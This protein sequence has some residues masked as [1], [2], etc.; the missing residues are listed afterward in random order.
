MDLIDAS[1]EETS[2]S[3]FTKLPFYVPVTAR[4]DGLLEEF[5]RTHQEMAVVV[6]EYGS[7][8]GVLT[9]E[10]VVEEIVG[11]V[12]D[13]FDR[14]GK[15]GFERS[16]DGAFIVDGKYKLDLLEDKLGLRLPRA[17]YETVAGLTSHLFQKVPK[18]GETLEQDGLKITIIDASQ[19]TVR[20]VR[21]EL[22]GQAGTGSKPA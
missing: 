17:G 16:G 9:L 15:A 14:P 7:A 11:D 6:D 8:V 22:T 20:R 1:P 13:E 2:L 10:D 12:F 21:I 5:R 3:R 19:R 18:A 4:I